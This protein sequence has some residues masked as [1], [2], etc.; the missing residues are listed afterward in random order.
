MV[1]KKLLSGVLTLMVTLAGFAQ[2]PKNAPAP[3]IA[4][5]VLEHDFG[6]VI[7]GETPSYDF[8]FTNKGDAPLILTNVRA[9]CGCTTPHW[10]REP[11]KPGETGK[12]TA[13]YNSK[14]RPGAFH[15]SITVQTNDPD[16]RLVVLI[17]KGTVV[18][19]GQARK[20][21][22]SKKPVKSPVRVK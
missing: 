11:I 16:E 1:M 20:A 3:D 5:K 18:K 19:K 8:E 13:V 21:A 12:I 2:A 7:E 17:I 10:P 15:K 22:K 9:S 4:F 6:E 14:G